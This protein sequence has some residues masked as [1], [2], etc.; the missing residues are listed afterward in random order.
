M[1][2]IRVHLWGRGWSR[3]QS[4]CDKFNTTEACSTERSSPAAPPPLPGAHTGGGGTAAQ[5]AAA[6]RPAW[7]PPRSC[8]PG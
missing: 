7:P 4:Q 3:Q 2:L 5:S 6:R 8:W 1:E